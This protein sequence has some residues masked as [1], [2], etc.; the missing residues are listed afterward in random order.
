VLAIDADVSPATYPSDR[1]SHLMLNGRLFEAQTQGHSAGSGALQPLCDCWLR[2][3]RHAGGPLLPD[4]VRILVART[5]M[6]AALV[7]WGTC[8]RAAE[9][10][11]DR[12]LVNGTVLTVDSQDSV[13]EA[14][15]IRGGRIVAVGTTAAIEALAGPDADRIDLHGLTATPGLLDAHLHLSSGGLLRLTQADLSFPK[16]KS[17]DDVSAVVTERRT[18]AAEGEWLLGRGW[19]EGKLAERRYILASDLDPVSEGHPAWLTHTMGHYGTAN[20]MALRLAGIDRDTPDPPGGVIDRDDAG[21][22]TGVLKESAMA[23]VKRLIPPPDA[24][25]MREAIAV[26]AD[27]LNREC[28]IGAK[29][30]G[31]GYSLADDPESA[32]TAWNA[33]R[34]VLADGDLSLRV[35]ALWRSPVTLDAARAL[36]ERIVPFSRPMDST[37]DDR[38][39]SGGIKIFADGSGGA[40][41]AWMWKDWN[42]ERTALDE[43][44]RGYPAIDA[45]LLRDLIM[46]YHDAGLH[47]GVHAIGDRAIDWTVAALTLALIRNPRQGMRHSIIHANIPTD[48]AMDTMAALQQNF[49]AAYP[50]P[51]AAFTWW[52][53]DTYAGNFGEARSHRLNPFRSFQQRGIQWAGGSDYSVT[54]FPARYGIWASMVRQPLLGV[55][56]SDAFGKDEAIDVRTALRSFT[57]WA[58]QQMFLEKKTGSIEVGKYADIALWDTNLYTAEPEAIRDMQ[59]Q[60]TLL[61]GEIVY[62]RSD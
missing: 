17:I 62:R 12:I 21:E 32:T 6:I 13:A 59:C 40:R 35:F 41:T 16:I 1:V 27:E 15:A 53:G 7:L 55:W 2:V 14:V 9:P 28:M 24:E 11:A 46:L 52:I 29:D 33:Y 36:A 3:Q 57:L 47:I 8:S 37:G 60:M 61:E 44:N 5:L 18:A 42:R 25:K 51:Q 56:G 10:R 58:A 48:L 31:I 43:G 49:D 26:M 54:P 22:P 38:L 19:D 4:E 30:P 34:Q 23:L 39:I 20:S 50:E 45:I